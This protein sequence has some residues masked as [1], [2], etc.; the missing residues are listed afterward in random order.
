M[1]SCAVLALLLFGACNSLVGAKSFGTG[2]DGGGSGSDAGGSDANVDGASDSPVDAA[3]EV[4]F[5]GVVSG[6]CIPSSS[7]DGTIGGGTIDTDHSACDPAYSDLCLMTAHDFDISGA[8]FVVGS[9][10]LVL[11]AY[12]TIQIEAGAYIDASANGAMP[13]AGAQDVTATA[14]EPNA[15]PASGMNSQ[16]NDFGSGGGAGGQGGITGGAGGAG[17]ASVR[18]HAGGQPHQ[19]NLSGFVGGC[20]GQSGADYLIN[21]NPTGSG[22]GGGGGGVLYLAASN[23]D[24][25]GALYAAGGGGAGGYDGAGGGGGGAGGYIG[26][27]VLAAPNNTIGVDGC[28]VAAN[29]GGGGGGGSGAAT[30]SGAGS[31][32]AHGGADANAVRTNAPGG[33]GSSPGDGTGGTGGATTPVSGQVGLDGANYGGGGGGG[34]GG[35]IYTPNSLTVNCALAFAKQE[36]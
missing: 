6:L 29:G 26:F 23:V 10:P 31:D 15:D 7:Q 12:G 8:T 20:A 19:A 21:G 22:A 30:P 16:L 33:T 17:N 9:R 4:C 28:I 2:G 25:R 1:R 36:F 27:Q 11:A 3:D 35:V 13:G 14:C 32:G 34:G 18:D 24:L 5:T